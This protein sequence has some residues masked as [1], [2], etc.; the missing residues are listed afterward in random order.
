MANNDKVLFQIDSVLVINS[1]LTLFGI[2]ASRKS[3]S[4]TRN[5]KSGSS[6]SSVSVNRE[7]IL[8]ITS[9][10]STTSTQQYAVSM[11]SNQAVSSKQ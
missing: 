11:S 6:T 5:N 7:S 8:L 4:G 1:V 3:G 10:T 9:I 2:G